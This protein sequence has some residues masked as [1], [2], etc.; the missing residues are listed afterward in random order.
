[1]DSNEEY[2]QSREGLGDEGATT[3]RAALALENHSQPDGYT[4]SFSSSHLGLA[5]TST[6]QGCF[7]YWKGFEPF[8]LLDYKSCLVAFMQKLTFQ[9]GRPLSPIAEEGE[10]GTELLEHSLRA[11]NSP[12]HQVRMASHCNAED[13]ELDPQY[14]NEQ[15]VDVSV[16]EPTADAPQDEDEEHQRIWRVKNA[17]RAQHKRNAQNRAREPRDLNNAFKEVADWEYYTSIGAIP[18]ATILAQQLPPNP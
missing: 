10:S 12:N 3:R 4:E 13:D 11:N 1:L 15:L 8:E 7:M 18:E 5:I 2:S 6:L 17:K 16:D 9:E 14:N